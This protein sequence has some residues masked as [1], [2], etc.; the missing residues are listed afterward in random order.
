M[1][2]LSS[3]GDEE[4]PGNGGSPLGWHGMASGWIFLLV[5]RF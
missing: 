3:K 2:E 1:A 4:G 5:R